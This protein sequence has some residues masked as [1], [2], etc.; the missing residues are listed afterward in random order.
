MKLKLFFEDPIIISPLLLQDMLVLHIKE[1]YHLF[2]SE[3]YKKDL[4][5]NFRTLTFRVP[6]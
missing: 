4:D 6:K 2:Y 3:K 5:D 1:K